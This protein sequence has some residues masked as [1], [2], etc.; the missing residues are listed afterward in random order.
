MSAFLHGLPERLPDGERVLWQGAPDWRIMARDVLHARKLALYFGIIAAWVGASALLGGQ[1]AGQALLPLSLAA[2][3]G[4]IPVAL[5]V[6]DA[7]LVA[8]SAVYTVTDRRIV[9]RIGVAMPLTINLPFGRL[10]AADMVCRP[11]GSGDVSV[12]LSG[13][14]K[15]AFAVL[16]PH[17]RS[18]RLARAQPTL[19]ALRDVQPVAQLLARTLA[20]SADRPAPVLQSAAPPSGG[21]TSPAPQAAVPA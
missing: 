6:G 13:R 7:R 5:A 18:W 1:P 16:W 15:L 21:S 10:A 17:T 9:M 8:R 14:D 2:A 4:A 19:R 12:S 11:D 3:L 20:A